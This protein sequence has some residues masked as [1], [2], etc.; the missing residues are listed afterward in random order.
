MV[1]YLAVTA[2][3]LWPWAQAPQQLLFLW[4]MDS[5]GGAHP[6]LHTVNLWDGDTGSQAGGLEVSGPAAGLQQPLVGT[7]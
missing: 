5:R 3:I 4:G 6:A 7:V 2:P 1:P